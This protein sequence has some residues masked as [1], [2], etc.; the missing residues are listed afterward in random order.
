MALIVDLLLQ[1]VQML[2]K[3]MTEIVLQFKP[4]PL[5]LFR[6]VACAGDVCDLTLSQPNM[7]V[8]RIQPDEGIALRFSAKRPAMQFVVESVAM[9]FSYQ[10][11]WNLSLP[12]AYERLLMDAMRGDASLFTRSDQV[13]AAWQAIDPILQ[14]W[15]DPSELPIH[16]YSPGSWGPD[17]ADE[18]I[19][20]EGRT[21]RNAD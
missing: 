6:T 18:L 3:R 16:A 17:A 12:E 4:P 21:W 11:T 5:Q 19:S 20:R 1:A 8:F 9:N 10:Q 14:A 7:L 13:E 15:Q 2:K